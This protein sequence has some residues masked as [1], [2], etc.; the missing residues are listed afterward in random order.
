MGWQDIEVL[1]EKNG[2]PYVIL[3]GRAKKI[4]QKK[5]MKQVFISLSHSNDYAIAQAIIIGDKEG[6]KNGYC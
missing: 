3:K 1:S 6:N 5:G 2:K 4:A